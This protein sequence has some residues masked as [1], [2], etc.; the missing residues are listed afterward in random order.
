MKKRI[1]S[2]VII[3]VLTLVTAVFFAYAQ[4]D[5]SSLRKLIVFYSPG[6]HRCTEI[7]GKILP[8]IEKKFKGKI[9]LEY[10]DIDDIE[11]YKFLLGLEKASGA[12]IRNSLPVFYIEG[13]FLNGDREIRRDLEPFIA[14]SLRMSVRAKAQELQQIDLISRFKAFTLFAIISVG[15]VDGINPC[16]FTVI[17]FFISFLALQGYVKRELVGIG[18][19]F[20]FAVFVTYLL[21]GLGAFG[22][23][24]RLNQFWIV[25]K[26]INFFIGS[27]S[28]VLG[29]LALYDFFKFKKTKETKDLTLQLPQAVKNQIH[30]I[31]GLHYRVAKN[32]E[33]GVSKKHFFRLILSALITGFLV[34]LLEAVCTGQTYLPTITFIL[35]TTHLKLQAFVYLVLYNFMFVV[36]L[37]AILVFALLGVTSDRFSQILKRHLATIKILMAVLFFGLGIFLIWKG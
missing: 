23:L 3:A 15:L 18:L 9:Q 37:L 8:E 33:G 24:Y 16:A 5:N 36:P 11:N 25:S 7:K 4:E 31:V 12:K 21:I 32:Q 13:N 2:P 14:R 17:V 27:F 35:K 26:V 30:K 22:F 34:S 29:T 10:R 28:I 19:C 20:I 1:I 6:C